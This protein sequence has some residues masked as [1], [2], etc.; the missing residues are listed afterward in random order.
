MAKLLFKKG[1]F[2][3]LCENVGGLY[4]SGTNKLIKRAGTVSHQSRDRTQKSPKEFVRMLQSMGHMSVLE[5]SW[6]VFRIYGSL[7]IIAKLFLSNSLFCISTDANSFLISGN[8]RMFLEGYKKT[9]N[10]VLGQLLDFLH[11]RNPVLFP[12]PQDGFKKADIEFEYNPELKTKKEKLLHIAVTIEFNN[13]SRGFTHEDVR[14]RNGD[15][16][17][18]AYTQESTRY[19]DYSKEEDGEKEM[20]FVLPYR[21]ISSNQIVD[22]SIIFLRSNHR[23]YK[24]TIDEFTDLLE[25]WYKRLRGLGL[26]PEEARQWLPIGIKSQIVQTYNLNEWRHWLKIRAQ[27]PAHLEIRT[28]AVE[29]LKTFQKIFPNVFDDFKIGRKKNNTPYAAYIGK[30]ELA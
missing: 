15:G 17:V 2:K 26:K 6:Y 13:H 25:D 14:S 29:L 8:A 3:I 4:A 9:E 16:K 27:K 10:R 22:R 28:T 18:V 1:S 5:H 23:E 30:E 12:A 20:E 11:K 19:V 7:G 21:E 24:F